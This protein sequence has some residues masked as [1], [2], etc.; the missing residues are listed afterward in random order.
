VPS[1]VYD[2]DLGEPDDHFADIHNFA[3]D[4]IFRLNLMIRER[5][6][7]RFLMQNGLQNFKVVLK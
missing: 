1:K 7:S 3:V 5:K 4:A 6:D 2:H